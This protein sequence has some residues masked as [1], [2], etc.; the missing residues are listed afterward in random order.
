MY[1]HSVD[2]V[3]TFV[4]NSNGIVGVRQH[5]VQLPSSPSQDGEHNNGFA[6]V[7]ITSDHL[8]YS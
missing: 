5:F 2:K 3:S 8:R 6:N 7:F 1:V 4:F